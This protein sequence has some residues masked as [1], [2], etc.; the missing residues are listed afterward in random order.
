MVIDSHAVPLKL[1]ERQFGIRVA[2]VPDH[3]LLTSAAFILAV[4]AQMPPEAVSFSS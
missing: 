1:E 3:E 4:A 2:V